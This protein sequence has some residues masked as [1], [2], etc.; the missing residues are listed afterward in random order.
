MFVASDFIA[1]LSRHCVDD[2]VQ[3]GLGQCAVIAL[4]DR[5]VTC[6]T[7]GQDIL[8]EVA[9]KGPGMSLV[10]CGNEGCLICLE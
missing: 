10:E 8:G 5:D 7:I 3:H 2:P 1:Q 9:V 6:L 4:I